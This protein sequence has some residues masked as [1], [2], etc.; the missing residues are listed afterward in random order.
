MPLIIS[1]LVRSIASVGLLAL[2]AISLHAQQPSPSAPSSVAYSARM[3]AKS[4]YG[5]ALDL[6]KKGDEASLRLAI[7]A[8][9]EA[10]SL[11]RAAADRQTEADSLAHLANNNASLNEVPKAIEYFDQ[12]AM[13]YRALGK[14]SEEADMLTS[15]GGVYYSQGQMPKALEK[16]DQAMPLRQ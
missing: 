1:T 14:P 4:K 7:A 3:A 9:E 5:E 6:E 8:F 2:F 16:L 11:S 15:L 13:L 10:L 12:A